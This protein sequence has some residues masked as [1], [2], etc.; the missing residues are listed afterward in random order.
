M[1][2]AQIQLQNALTTTFLANLAFLSEYDNE[3][4][5]RVDELS[6][7]IENGSYKEK[8]ALEFI[9]ESGDFDIYD[10]VNNKY[11]YNKKPKKINDDLVRKIQFDE[12]DSI[13]NLSPDFLLKNKNKINKKN[14]FSI[15]ELKELSILTLNDMQ[16]YTNITKDYLENRN[17][18]IKKIKKFIFLGTLLGRH[19][20]EIAKKID[21]EVYLVCERN[22][23]IFRLSLFTVDYTVL[24]KKGVAFSIM[25]NQVNESNKIVNFLNTNVFDNYLIKFSTTNI[26]IDGFVDN[27]LNLLLTLNPT[28]YDYNRNLY[29]FFNRTTQYVNSNYKILLF[30]KIKEVCNFFENI[31]ILY[32]A[33][34]PSL[35]ENIDWIKQNQNKFFIVTIGAAYRKL[36]QNDIRIDM[37]TTLDE[38]KFLDEIQ[39][40]E[41]NVSKISKNTIILASA[42]THEKIL[43]KFIQENLFLYEVFTPLNK[44][45]IAFSGFS[46]GEITLDIL[47]Q[48]NAKKIYL[49]GLDL[50]L[51]Q[52]TGNTH[53]I[54]SGSGTN[55]LDLNKELTRDSFDYR[56]SLVRTKGNLLDEVY[57]TPIFFASIKS[58][59]I[60]LLNKQNVEIYN[61]ST[62]GA[63]FENTKSLRIKDIKI[64][65]EE[66]IFNYKEFSSF[67]LEKSNYK[68]SDEILNDLENE[69]LFI[70]TE[71]KIILKEFKNVSVDNFDEFLEI[72]EILKVTKQKGFHILNRILFNYFEI[73]F[74][75]L[76][77]YFNDKEIEN[78]KIKINDIKTI[79][80]KQIKNILNDYLNCLKR[81]TK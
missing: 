56:N 37:I 38:Q 60:K 80:V 45:N 19:I 53:S 21:A 62:H 7:M 2:E 48:L 54:E 57:T 13:F 65:E 3:L 23:E 58:L 69:I 32:L 47:L 78:E 36:I 51:N 44:K 40:D 14:R 42:I 43:K 75:Y 9:I 66:F 10:I 8:Y 70:N 5:H 39:F 31:P 61:L 81:I 72:I 74:P 50:A 24:A 67:L 71:L 55:I 15:E 46:V 22:L 18:K 35:D 12:K 33:A 29:I 30:D 16:E 11:L 25:D 52:V 63:Y 79:F 27:I 4:Y 17:K 73:L 59:E 76:N 6:R 64:N 68:I 77:Y 20:P 49:L 34:G 28:I 41:Y 1:T 26:N